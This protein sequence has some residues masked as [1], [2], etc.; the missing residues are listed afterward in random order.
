MA[1]KRR[2][3][4]P[5]VASGCGQEIRH[6]RLDVD[7]CR[8]VRLKTDA[9]RQ[10][11]L[12]CRDHRT[13]LFREHDWPSNVCLLYDER[14][15]HHQAATAARRST[16][17]RFSQFG[18][19]CGMIKWFQARQ[20]AS[21]V[22]PAHKCCGGTRSSPSGSTLLGGPTGGVSAYRLPGQSGRHHRD[23]QAL[24]VRTV[25]RTSFPLTRER[26]IADRFCF[27]ASD[28][29]ASQQIDCRHRQHRVP[30]DALRTA[31]R[32]WR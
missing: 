27:Q 14:I 31:D 11:D 7:L 13:C 10:R 4:S 9:P 5:G 20:A 22:A 15:I 17:A 25:D 24:A 23:S 18:V 8:S 30:G 3:E 6:L 26:G 28:I 1:Q 32:R 19:I 16:P 12:G 29:H 21:S 2:P